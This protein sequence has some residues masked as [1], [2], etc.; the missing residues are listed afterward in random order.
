MI[1]MPFYLHAA[2]LEAGLLFFLLSM[3]LALDASVVM[4]HLAHR[5]QANV[6][7]H[8]FELFQMERSHLYI[9][10]LFSD[11]TCFL[12][13][14]AW[15]CQETSYVPLISKGLGPRSALLATLSVLL[16]GWGSAVAWLKFIGDNLVRFAGGSRPLN[17][18]LLAVPLVACAW[19]DQIA[20]LER[21]SS[22]GLLAG[23]C[24]VVLILVLACQEAAE[25]PSYVGSQP[26]LR[27]DTF[28]V[29]MGIAVFCNEGMVVMSSEVSSQM[30]QP[31]TFA[32]AVMLAV[33]YFTVNYLL[34]ALG[35]D[36][37]YSYLP[38]EMVAQ[39]V[40]MS[41]AFTVTPMHRSCVLCYVLQHLG[42]A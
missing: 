14:S 36:F 22:V 3:L 12:I 17:L 37:L 20:W 9:F 15:K 25:W 8:R 1:A 27:L 42:V 7:E 38:G 28:P 5:L 19:V 11:F 13:T 24:F 2:G 16:A 21:F 34:L 4:H 40:T 39:E 32:K 33:G 29:A 6:I 31:Q 30:R 26:F 35:G 10:Q 23:Q 41:E 18:A